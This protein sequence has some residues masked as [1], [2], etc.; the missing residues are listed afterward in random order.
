MKRITTQKGMRPFLSAIIK[1]GK[2]SEIMN[3]KTI[4]V[5]LNGLKY[6]AL[7]DKEKGLYVEAK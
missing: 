3:G 7:W 6:K 4:Q 5:E 1:S 2:S